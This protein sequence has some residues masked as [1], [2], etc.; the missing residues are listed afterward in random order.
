MSGSCWTEHYVSS[1]LRIACCIQN[2]CF[3]GAEHAVALARKLGDVRSLA[4][5]LDDLGVD[6]FDLGDQPRAL[7]YYAHALSLSRQV[8]DKGGAP[9]FGSA[10]G[11]EASPA[12]PR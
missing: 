11:E 10:P 3:P 1:W 2:A 12:P 9:G 7:Q 4:T 5:A 8:G 6:H